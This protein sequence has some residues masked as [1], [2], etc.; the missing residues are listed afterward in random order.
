LI[1]VLSQVIAQSETVSLTDPLTGFKF[2]GSQNG[3]NSPVSNGALSFGVAF[4]K[5]LD[6]DEYIGYL[7]SDYT[8]PDYAA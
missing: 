8:S 1:I 3:Y 5:N 7:V 2:P 4:P 6:K